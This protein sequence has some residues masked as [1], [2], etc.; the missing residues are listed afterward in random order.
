MIWRV[1]RCFAILDQSRP[2]A[3]AHLRRSAAPDRRIGGPCIRRTRARRPGAHFRATRHSHRPAAEQLT[4]CCFRLLPS[5]SVV[6]RET[7]ALD[8]VQE[9][10]GRLLLLS[11]GAFWAHGLARPLAAESDDDQQS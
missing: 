1:R 11:E 5:A 3:I 10:R 8:D 4:R 2:R 6:H 9:R 7:P